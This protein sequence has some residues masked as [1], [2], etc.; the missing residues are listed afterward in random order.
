MGSAGRSTPPLSSLGSAMMVVLTGLRSI[1]VEM[2]GYVVVL[3][4]AAGVTSSVTVG[5][6][7]RQES[8]NEC[9]FFSGSG[10]TNRLNLSSLSQCT[11]L[12]IKQNSL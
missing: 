2:A 12:N 6:E 3:R 1:V 7:R 9:G 4:G 10:T 5:A 8:H 11:A